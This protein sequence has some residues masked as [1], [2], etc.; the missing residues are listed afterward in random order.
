MMETRVWRCS[1]GQVQGDSLVIGQRANE[2][3]PLGFQQALA[4]WVRCRDGVI[5]S[6]ATLS[7]KPLFAVNRS[8]R[9][10][11]HPTADPNPQDARFSGGWCRRPSA[12][13]WNTRK[14][15]ADQM[16][17]SM[18]RDT[19]WLCAVSCIRRVNCDSGMGV[20][21]WQ[22]DGRQARKQASKQP[23]N[24]ATKQPQHRTTLPPRILESAQQIHKQPTPNL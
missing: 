4:R 2:G 17:E 11:P 8:A 6:Q 23:S 13:G 10:C 5:S 14:H 7:H 22:G 24:Q 20:S 12:P 9:G 16:E 1:A 3:L 15:K 19:I 21:A 18:L